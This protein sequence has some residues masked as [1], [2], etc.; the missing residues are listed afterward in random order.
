MNKMKAGEDEKM[1]CQMLNLVII[2]N[3][4]GYQQLIF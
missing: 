1:Y 3:K 4:K 2:N